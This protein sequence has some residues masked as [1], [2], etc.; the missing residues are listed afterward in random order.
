MCKKRERERERERP[1]TARCISNPVAAAARAHSAAAE[2]HKS[3]I[4]DATRSIV[5][6]SLSLF[7]H[8]VATHICH[9]FCLLHVGVDELEEEKEEDK[10]H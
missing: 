4:Q 9:F 1:A 10:A 3:R 6:L 2:C 5:S 7:G 8:V